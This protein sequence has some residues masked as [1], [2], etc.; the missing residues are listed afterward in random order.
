VANEVSVPLLPCRDVDEI[1]D[2]YAAL[3]FRRTYRQHSPSPYVALRRE[4]LHLH[5]FGITDF[6]PQTSYGSVL[7]LVDDIGELH[8]AFA[9]GMRAAYGKVLISGLPRMTRPRVRR[10]SNRLTG[11]SV[12]DPGGNWIRVTAKAP[13][14][15]PG[16]VS[17][18]GQALESAVALADSE[19]DHETAAKIL[20]GALGQVPPDEDPA[21]MAEALA[22]RAELALV[23]DDVRT[24]AEALEAARE[25]D[26]TGAEL[27]ELAEA[28][29]AKTAPAAEIG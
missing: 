26:D 19:G 10:N 7:I 14:R 1:A 6:D 28:L 11:F 21:L 5:F 24:A 13:V 8:R 15:V 25:L 12:V 17:H 3:G 16:P 22:Y 23:L 2:F 4:D 27:A 29:A 18:L 20:D 9:D